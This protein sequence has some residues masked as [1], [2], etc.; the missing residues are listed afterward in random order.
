MRGSKVQSFLNIL[1]KYFG[2]HNT[3]VGRRNNNVCMA[4]Y[5]GNTAG[6]PCYAWSCIS[7]SRLGNNIVFSYFGEL[8]AHNVIVELACYN[9]N[10]ILRDYVK[11]A[12]E[13]LLQ[14]CSSFAEEIDKLLRILFPTHWPQS[15]SFPASQNDTVTIIIRNFHRCIDFRFI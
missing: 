10:I 8:F 15:F 13:S 5:L 11:K 7:V 12:V 4:V 14:L 6:S 1:F 2:L 3:L 9:E